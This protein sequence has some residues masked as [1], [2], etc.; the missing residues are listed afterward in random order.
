AGAKKVVELDRLEFGLFR[1]EDGFHAWRNDCP[2]Q[3]GPVCQGRIYRRVLETLDTGR[4]SLGR[5]Y[6]E[7]RINIVCPW[8]GFEYDIRTGRH[9]GNEG[10]ALEPVA[11][12]VQGGEVYVSL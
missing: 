5:R 6:D 7:E 1:L 3:G 11:V 4:R 2:H 12:E 10:L 9:P 8:H